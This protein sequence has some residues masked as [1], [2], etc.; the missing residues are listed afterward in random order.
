MDTTTFIVERVTD[1]EE[2]SA[3]F[4]SFTNKV[5]GRGLLI[6]EN[7]Q[8]FFGYRESHGGKIVFACLSHSPPLKLTYSIAFKKSLL[9]PIIYRGLPIM[10]L[11]LIALIVK[12]FIVYGTHGVP[13][14][15][16]YTIG[17]G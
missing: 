6:P 9:K 13:C 10:G 11:E 14:D 5:V 2:T 17:C 7:N 16:I 12:L 15:I 8:V 3:T 4:K 1:Q